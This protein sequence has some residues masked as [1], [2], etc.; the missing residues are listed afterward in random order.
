MKMKNQFSVFP[1][2]FSPFTFFSYLCR[3]KHLKILLLLLVVLPMAC[4]CGRK[5]RSKGVEVVEPVRYI[6]R[7]AATYPHS[8]EA[9][10]QGLQYADGL[11][12]EGT[13]EYGGSTLRTT[14]L[15]TGKEEILI[16]LPTSEFGEGITLLG[17]KI[18]Q[19]TWNENTCHVYDRTTRRKLR[20]FRYAGEGWGLTTD[21]KKLYFSNGTSTLYRLDPETFRREASVV[22]TLRGVPV[23]YINELEWIDGKIWA[24][25]Y[26]S[27]Q[28]AIINPQSGVIEG[29]I[30][31]E[32]ILP[33]AERELM[34]DVLNGIAYDEAQKRIF[35][36][37]K[38]WPHI[39]QIE[40]IKQ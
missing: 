25:I 39:Y 24:N 32:G 38:K 16:E 10:T 5:S 20:D 23:E 21:G 2:Q 7:I 14:D 27:D 28:I 6:Y 31:L 11:L 4:G 37:G 17:D 35:I 33:E 19:L 26:L 40:L 3:M 18:Y 13:G 9:Y 1:F 8:R 30:D 15:T 29:L 34:T 22:V 12:W 36:T